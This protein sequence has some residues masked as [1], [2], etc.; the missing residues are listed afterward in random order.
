[1]ATSAEKGIVTVSTMHFDRAGGHRPVKGDLFSETKHPRVR[2]RIIDHW[3]DVYV[4]EN[5]AEPNIRRYAYAD[6]LDD[7]TRYLK[8]QR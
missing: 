6:E 2:W 1:M 3:R 7:E 8:A 4:L 5:T